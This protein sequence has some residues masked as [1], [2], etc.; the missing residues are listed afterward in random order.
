MKTLLLLIGIAATLVTSAQPS[1]LQ[2]YFTQ[3]REAYKAGDYAKFYSQIREAYKLHPYH[4]EVLHQAG[5]ASALTN[6]PDEALQHLNEAI[7]MKADFD[8][9]NPDLKSLVERSDFKK[10]LL[11]Q[12]ELQTKVIRSDTAFILR[13]RTL[14]I[15]CIAP[16]ESK[17]TFYL[18][19]I[20]KRKIV[21]V[22]QHGNAKDFTSSAQDGLCSVFGIKVD[23]S[24]K[25]LWACASP[26]PEMENYD[27]TAF[28]GVYK[29]DIKTGKLLARYSS[30]EKKQ[31][32]FGD[33][34][35]SPSGKPFVADSRNNTIFFVNEVTG[36]LDP[37]FS[38][39]E[40][41]NLQGL[42]FTPDG[43]YLFI[44]DYIKG[45][46]RLNTETKTLSFVHQKFPL[47]MKSIDG[48]TFYN[49]SLIGIQN[50]V[51]PMRVTQYFL[52][53]AMDQFIDYKIL[54]RAHPAFNE[55]TIGCISDDTFYYI[56]NSLWSGYTEQRKLKPVGELQDVVVLKLKMK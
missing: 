45:V 1:A 51:Y 7:Q 50:M 43:R 9:S 55:P 49:N 22:D 13:D 56:A 23:A 8:L 34:I 18:G 39:T 27:S 32:I 6:R 40:F 38:S 17:N 12:K 25:I 52:N 48:L 28:S 30:P 42:A 16:G 37:F 20:H 47:S 2:T 31:S 44:A 46:F 10:L 5:I 36:T 21:R 54:D 35:L 19:S 33:L 14:H 3:A 15:E 41:W 26:M 4:H 53:D 24:K 11:T 29:Y